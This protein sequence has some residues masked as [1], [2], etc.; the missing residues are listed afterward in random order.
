MQSTE[1]HSFHFLVSFSKF[2]LHIAALNHKNNTDKNNYLHYF[3]NKI[4]W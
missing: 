1:P 4:G 2:L 3:I